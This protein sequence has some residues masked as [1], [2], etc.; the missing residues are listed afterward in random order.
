MKKKLHERQ[1]ILNLKQLLLKNTFSVKRYGK[2][3]LVQI[4]EEEVYK[5]I[6]ITF[7]DDEDSPFEKIEP[8]KFNTQWGSVYSRELA[9]F[10]KEKKMGLCPKDIVDIH[11]TR[12]DDEN[13]LMNPPIIEIKLE[14]DT[15][16]SHI[17]IGGESIKL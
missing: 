9:E 11:V 1:D 15:L 3:L 5:I 6:T 13:R 12:K 10:T 4:K 17:I 8:H 16:D 14:K 7:T 2:R